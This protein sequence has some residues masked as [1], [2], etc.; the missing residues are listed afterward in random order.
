MISDPNIAYILL[1]LGLYGVL[2]ELYNPGAILPGIVGVICF[3]MAFYS[4]HTLPIN[5]AGVALIVFA[6][7]LFLLDIKVV[8]HGL[9][10]IGGVIS[11]L[12]GS[13]MLYRADGA[14]EMNR[15]SW[16]VINTISS[17][18]ISIC[19]SLALSLLYQKRHI[20]YSA[21]LHTRIF[22]YGSANGMCLPYLS[23]NADR[24]GRIQCVERFAY[25][26]D[27]AVDAGNR[28]QALSSQPC[29]DHKKEERCCN[30]N[31]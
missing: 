4:M 15:I 27:H 21:Y 22:V 11:L 24:P 18:S 7:I 26:A 23:V 14:M 5:Y 30:N 8:S 3:T 12:L 17:A 6:I 19:R 10:T 9:L 2:F 31:R 16:M 28:S 13:L 29:P 25:L 1:L 20:L